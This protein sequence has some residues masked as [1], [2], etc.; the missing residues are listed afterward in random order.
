M[1]YKLMPRVQVRW[2]DVWLGAVVTALLFTIGKFLIGLYIG[3]S[4]VAS[5]FGAAGSLVVVFVW[6][7]YSAQIFLLGAEFTWVYA[8][9]ARLDA[10]QRGR[11]T[12]S[13]QKAAQAPTQAP[14]RSDAARRPAT[15]R[16]R[17]AAARDS[18]R[19]RRRGGR[20][21]SDARATSAPASPASSPCASFFLACCADSEDRDLEHQRRQ[22]APAA[23]ARVARRGR[24]RRRRAAGAEG[25][26]RRVP[27]RPRSRRRLRRRLVRPANLERRRPARARHRSRSRRGAAL[28]GD[29]AD[30]H[31]RYIEA[32][33]E[34]RPRR[35]DLPAQR[36]PAARARSSTTSWPGSSACSRTRA[37]SPRA[38]TRSSSPATTTS[39]RPTPTSTRPGRG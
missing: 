37:R 22:P 34:R 8:Q 5:G 23:P 20:R 28:P 3:K 14:A 29:D 10:R 38:A 9:H 32:A 15:R 36:Q 33:V 11:P 21:G 7:Y 12:R 24:A 30:S 13:R 27:A 31:A 16:A 39:C 1:I 6:V 19:L 4:G 2:H 18:G 25:G 35:L 17:R 26:R